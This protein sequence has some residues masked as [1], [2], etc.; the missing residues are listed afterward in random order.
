LKIREPQEIAIDE[1][2]R[3]SGV[4]P[5]NVLRSGGEVLLG[6]YLETRGLHAFAR[7]R[8]RDVL[9]YGKLTL[10]LQ[11]SQKGAATVR[12]RGVMTEYSQGDFE[13]EGAVWVPENAPLGKVELRVAFPANKEVSLVPPLAPNGFSGSQR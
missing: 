10:E 3:P 12:A 9:P 2:G 4:G 5:R 13:M 6:G 8:P 7:Y 11:F 1:E